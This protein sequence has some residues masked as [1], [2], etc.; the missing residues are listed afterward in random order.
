MYITASAARNKKNG[1]FFT[2]DG[3]YG[4]SFQDLNDNDDVISLK[5]KGWMFSAG[6]GFRLGN[7]SGD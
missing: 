2:I 1:I 4:W 6:V 5:N 7:S 3:R